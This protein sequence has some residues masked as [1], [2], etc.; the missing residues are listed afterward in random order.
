[1]IQHL[2][3]LIHSLFLLSFKSDDDQHMRDSFDRYYMPLIDIKDFNELINNFFCD[4]PIKTN[5][6]RMENLTKCQDPMIIQKEAY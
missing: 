6:N 4:Q 2:R 5:K 3:I 1:M